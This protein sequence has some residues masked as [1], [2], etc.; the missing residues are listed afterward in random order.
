MG[1]H[2]TSSSAAEAP[3][4]FSAGYGPDAF[5]TAPEPVHRLTRRERRAQE[6]ARL[7][8]QA[9]E[10][11]ARNQPPASAL[12][13]NVT[14]LTPL[15]TPPLLGE[16]SAAPSSAPTTPV[17]GTPVPPT[18]GT[19]SGLGSF[20]RSLEEAS[21]T[22]QPLLGE[23]APPSQAPSPVAP[24]AP[25][26]GQVPGTTGAPAWDA[27]VDGVRQSDEDGAARP[28]A[29]SALLQ[30]SDP[31]TDYRPEPPQV[32]S[33]QVRPDQEPPRQ[34]YPSQSS[35]APTPQYRPEPPAA[36]P[37]PA[38]SS[39][40]SAPQAEP[41]APAEPPAP[42][43][44]AAQELADRL[45][46][47]YVD[48]GEYPVDSEVVQLVPEQMCRR[49]HL[50]PI[51]RMG[52]RLVVAMANP[53]DVV[54]VDD[55]S[56]RTGLAVMPMVAE[57]GAIAETIDRYHRVDSELAELSS[58]ITSEAQQAQS[59][60]ALTDENVS[61]SDDE[62]P[63]IRF[64]N[65]LISQA[66]MDH[67]SDI[68]I[69]PQRDGLAVR[70]RIDGV[71]HEMQRA[72]RSMIA[73]VISRLKIMAGMDIAERRKPQD[74]RISVAQA[75]RSVDLR[76]ATLPTVWG[77]KVVM[78][79]LDSE[80][81][82]ISIDDLNLSPRNLEVFRSSF[83]KPHGMVLVTGPTG[84][85]K[86][87][88]LYSVVE[89][90]ARPEVNVITVEDPVEY[91]MNGVNQV[92]VNVKAGLTF[93]SALRSILRSDPDIVLIGEIRDRETAQIAIEASLTGHL[94]LSTLH[95]NDAPSAVTRLVEMG[96]EPFLVGSAMECVVAQRLARRLCPHCREAYQ[97]TRDELEGLRF[98][99]P[100][101]N[102][103]PTFWRP[104]GCQKCSGTGYSGRIAIH[105]VM[106]V[107]TGIERLAVADA[108]AS[109]IAAC[110]LQEGMVSLRDDGWA[111]AEQGLTSVDEVLRV[112][113]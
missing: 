30:Q 67:A 88:T 51:G 2:T 79:I 1:K 94:V 92:Q 55:V 97:P 80:G 43:R 65:L 17:N 72:S 21:A 106:Q 26:V 15:P 63:I 93:A 29:P 89:E 73:G 13:Q 10:E 16:S 71:L 8:A 112:T 7:E 48:L 107:D 32:Q 66:I 18:A 108:P 31:Q 64:V 56:T 12:P 85:G 109:D 96:V 78:R 36:D 91:R 83:N 62:A 27:A 44:S 81:S 104:R 68:H 47:P 19:G 113:A 87:T 45:Q 69:E 101:G 42:A 111:K 3:D 14:P 77:E 70:Y 75:G 105:E 4:Q 98:P 100:Q 25:S 33:T 95:T 35:S 41:A 23:T 99:L 49:D 46:L 20:L 82:H 53:R 22:N 86:S 59:T 40:P 57:P 76:V 50:I 37:A 11:A 38:A 28:L 34:S 5:L 9:A 61:D 39:T 58:V 84:S 24:S 52:D 90:V 110:A 60:T 6:R 74:G 103:M 102:P 54:A